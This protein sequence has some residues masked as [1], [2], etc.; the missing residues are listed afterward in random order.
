[1]KINEKIDIIYS[2]S[3]T[4]KLGHLICGS[5]AVKWILIVLHG[6]MLPFSIHYLGRTV[7]IIAHRLSTIQN[8]GNFYI[9]V[10]T[11]S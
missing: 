3:W 5:S 4:E 6:I 11:A 9:L 10:R 8:A 7:I 2:F 1:M